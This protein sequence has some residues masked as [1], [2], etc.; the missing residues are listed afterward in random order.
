MKTVLI[1]IL[2]YSFILTVVE[3]Y[4]D[5]S[6]YFE[7]SIP[8]VITAGPCMWI[9]L[10][11]LI[12]F[13]P[14]FIKLSKREKKYRK[15]TP[16]Q[17][18][19]TVRKVLHQYNKYNRYH[20]P[21]VIPGIVTEPGSGLDDY[22]DLEVKKPSNEW[23]NREFTRIWAYQREEMFAALMKYMKEWHENEESDIPSYIL[24]MYRGKIYELTEEGLAL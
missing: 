17:I 6:S 3:I 16:E 19:K 24:D 23:L 5:C 4:K 21:I 10:L 7:S 15:R 20:Y 9:V 14:I 8:D 18:D 13:K 11:V 2:V 1:T 12:L 22:R